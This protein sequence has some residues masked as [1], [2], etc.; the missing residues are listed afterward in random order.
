MWWR[1]QVNTSNNEQ[2]NPTQINN[3]H[4]NVLELTAEMLE[5][6]REKAR[7]QARKVHHDW[8]QRGSWLVCRSCDFEHATHVKVGKIYVGQENGLPKFVDI[9]Q[10]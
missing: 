7:E 5:D 3:E 1:H 9:E 4:K 6:I 2:K 10:S 8:V